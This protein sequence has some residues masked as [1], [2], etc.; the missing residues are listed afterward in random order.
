[1]DVG[2]TPPVAAAAAANNTTVGTS[3]SNS[4]AAAV[5]R[6]NGNGTL[7]VDSSKGRL[8]MDRMDSIKNLFGCELRVVDDGV[9]GRDENAAA[10]TTTTTTT[11][12]V[13]RLDAYKAPDD[14]QLID[15]LKVT[16]F[17]RSVATGHRCL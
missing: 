14:H 15:R 11:F 16:R 1:M 2:R 13:S 7:S 17:R 6:H 8:V 4:A 10:R 12:A 9:G 5:N 3:A